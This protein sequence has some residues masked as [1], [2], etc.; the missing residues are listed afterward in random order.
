MG[1]SPKESKKTTTR[2][3]RSKLPQTHEKLKDFLEKTN[4]VRLADDGKSMKCLLCCKNPN[5]DNSK[6]S[7]SGHLKY[8]RRVHRCSVR[9]EVEGSKTQKI[10]EFYG[11]VEK[12]PRTP[13]VGTQPDADIVVNVEEKTDLEDLESGANMPDTPKE[14]KK[15]RVSVSSD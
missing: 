12:R 5:L 11:P 15:S 3:S 9:A 1:K 4:D 8:F 6:R 10:D 13:R 7:N 14:V 2:K